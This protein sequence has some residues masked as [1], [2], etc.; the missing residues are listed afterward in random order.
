[1]AK[2]GTERGYPRRGRG[3]Q[4]QYS[5]IRRPMAH[6]REKLREEWRVWKEKRRKNLT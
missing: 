3:R 2:N 5:Q 1:M 6:M 4:Y